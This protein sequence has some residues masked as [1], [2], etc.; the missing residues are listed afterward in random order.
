M[1]ED[2]DT[3]S[4][5]KDIKQNN[6]AN[7][8]VEQKN[9]IIICSDIFNE[10]NFNSNQIEEILGEQFKLEINELGEIKL[11]GNPM[12]VKELDDGLNAFVLEEEEVVT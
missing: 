2:C 7:I 11:N 1:K 12:E 3:K 10:A 9:I 5:I 4:L 8:C 6:N